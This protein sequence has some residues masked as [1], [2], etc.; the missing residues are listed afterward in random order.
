[1]DKIFERVDARLKPMPS[2]GFTIK[3][4][5][6]TI[7]DSKIGGMPYWPK[8]LV[9]PTDKNGEKMILLAQL[10]F[11][12]LP[13]IENFP[14]KGILQ[15]F[16]SG[17]DCYGVNFD[18]YA[19]QSTFRVVY[20]ENIIED[21][22]ML[23]KP[24][25]PQYDVY[26]LP[27][28]RDYLLIPGEVSEMKA[29]PYDYRFDDIFVEEYNKDHDEKIDSVYDLDDD[30]DKV[31]ERNDRPS[32][33]IGGY[34]IFTQDDP[35]GYEKDLRDC[36]IVLFECDSYTKDDVDIM[37]GDCGIGVFIIPLE[38]LKNLDFSR[39]MYDYDCC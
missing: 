28:D 36:N 31:Y 33:F 14:T 4:Q 9:Y 35:R 1:M 21:E 24:Y 26:D 37:W 19:E 15:F 13:H 38:N 29:D 10:N 20:H 25:I 12:N 30:M 22:N 8:G 11:S 3:A 18:D 17:D 32:V 23:L 34:P 7:F 27:F 5:D 2:L 16:I 39:V 6:T